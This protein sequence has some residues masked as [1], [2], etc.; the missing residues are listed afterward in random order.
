MV[1]KNDEARVIGAFATEVAQHVEVIE[2]EIK[3][4]DKNEAL[5][6]VDELLTIRDVWADRAARKPVIHITSWAHGDV[7]IDPEDVQR[8]AKLRLKIV[9]AA[10]AQ[11][12]KK[13]QS[14]GWI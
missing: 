6:W 14:L 12:Q 7:K 5:L 13:L 11:L 4:G 2:S 9:S 10:L 1:N 3:K 8:L